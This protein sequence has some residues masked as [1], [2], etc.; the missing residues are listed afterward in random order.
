M[1]LMQFVNIDVVSQLSD[2]RESG[3]ALSMRRLSECNIP[4]P[5]VDVEVSE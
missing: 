3:F 4:Y 2:G 1:S 5:N